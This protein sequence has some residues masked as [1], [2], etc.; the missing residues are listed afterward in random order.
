[1][2]SGGNFSSSAKNLFGRF[3]RL[4]NTAGG[5]RRRRIPRILCVSHFK[6]RCHTM[7][8]LSICAQDDDAFRLVTSVTKALSPAGVFHRKNKVDEEKRKNIKWTKHFLWRAG[9]MGGGW[10]ESFQLW[11]VKSFGLFSFRMHGCNSISL[12]LSPNRI[13]IYKMLNSVSPSPILFPVA[14]D[15]RV[16][17]WIAFLW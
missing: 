14:A 11:I 3:K 4:N 9:K 7:M 15:L 6:C 13:T 5:G 12:S 1:M 10:G 17:S 8:S 2:K 16:D